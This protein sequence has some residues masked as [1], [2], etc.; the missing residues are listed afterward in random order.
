MYTFLAFLMDGVYKK[1]QTASKLLA[2]EGQS[3]SLL[4]PGADA[5]YRQELQD[6]AGFT[7]RRCD[8]QV[9]F[10]WL[11]GA[12]P[13]ITHRMDLALRTCTCGQMF[14]L[15]LPCRH[16]IAASMHFANE[17]AL[18]DS[19]D[20]IYKATTY[21]GV[22]RNLRIEIPAGGDLHK[23]QSLLPALPAR[24]TKYKKRPEVLGVVPPQRLPQTRP[25]LS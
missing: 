19:F 23:D 20:P 11:T 7:V 25:L 6:A 13:K 2:G 3:P 16:F 1:S 12:R 9:A 14:Q 4:T 15:G 17:A 18:L 21:A 10:A 22:H 8:E 5:I 24:T